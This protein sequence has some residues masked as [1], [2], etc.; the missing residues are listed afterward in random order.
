MKYTKFKDIPKFICQD[1]HYQVNM[2][3]ISLPRWVKEQQDDLKLELNPDFQRGHVWAEEQ[4]I[5]Y[6]EYLLKGGLSSRTI[7]FNMPGWM[8]T[9]WEGPFVC[10]DGLQRITAVLDFLDNKIKVFNSYFKDFEDPRWL[11]TEPDVI[12]CINDLKY[13]KDVL[14]WYIEMNT[15]GTVH[16]KEQI[17]K[18]KNLLDK[19]DGK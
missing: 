13:R 14:H 17:D 5:A 2:P 6:M 7:Y 10:V 16:T 18:V 8:H 19:E 1:G 15:G 4:K 3:I 12:I 11:C 9:N